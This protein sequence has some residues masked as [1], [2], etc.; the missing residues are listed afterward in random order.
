MKHTKPPTW[1]LY[2]SCR[3]VAE[4][5]VGHNKKLTADGIQIVN[6]TETKCSDVANITT[7][8]NNKREQ[9]SH[10][11]T[12]DERRW[13][14]RENTKKNRHIVE[15]ETKENYESH[16][17]LNSRRSEI[18]WQHQCSEMNR[19]SNQRAVFMKGPACLVNSANCVRSRMNGPLHLLPDRFKL[20]ANKNTG[21]GGA[22]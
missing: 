22:E 13:K 8:S 11:V 5:H 9:S 4:P 21:V 16:H 1:P 15:A 3:V 7:T 18:R 10:F 19:R 14:Y 12:K 20:N 2:V 17:L 6:E